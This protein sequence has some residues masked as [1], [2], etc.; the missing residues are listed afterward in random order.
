MFIDQSKCCST[1]EP[2]LRITNF[3]AIYTTNSEIRK[4]KKVND[5]ISKTSISVM[6]L[7]KPLAE[8]KNDKS[9]K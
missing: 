6:R 8:S 2:M 1:E 5:L 9:V 7:T 4:K 3:E